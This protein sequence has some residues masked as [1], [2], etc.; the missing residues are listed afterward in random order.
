MP[1]RGKVSAKR[2]ISGGRF[3]I[4]A[5]PSDCKVK[6]TIPHWGL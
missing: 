3:M 4:G 5:G 2:C 6:Q 1:L